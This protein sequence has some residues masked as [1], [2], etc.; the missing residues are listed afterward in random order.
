MNKTFNA[1][2]D[3]FLNLIVFS[4]AGTVHATNIHMEMKI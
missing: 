4:S 3:V 2:C 1:F